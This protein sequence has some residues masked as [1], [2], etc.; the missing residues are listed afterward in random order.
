MVLQIQTGCLLKESLQLMAHLLSV[1]KVESE[2]EEE[3][4]VEEIVEGEDILTIEPMEEN[5][6]EENN[7]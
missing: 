3:T 7:N 5:S 1:C 2:N 6:N 4:S